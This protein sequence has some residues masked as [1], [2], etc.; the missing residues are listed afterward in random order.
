MRIQEPADTMREKIGT[1]V[2]VAVLMKAMLAERGISGKIWQ[3]HDARRNKFHAILT[4]E[5]EG[6]TVYLELTPQSRKPWY[7]KEILYESEADFIAAY[8]KNGYEVTDVTDA[9]AIG[10]RPEFMLP[11]LG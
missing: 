7:G 3:L 10:S 2:D 1:C 4:F 5:A 6:K 9:A 8:E 11:R